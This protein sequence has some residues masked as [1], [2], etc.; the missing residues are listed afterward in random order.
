MRI[1]PKLQFNKHD[2]GFGIACILE[3]ESAKYIRKKRIFTLTCMLIFLWFTLGI[4]I[5][6]GE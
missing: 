2:F 4:C 1:E 6:V 3:N 5:T